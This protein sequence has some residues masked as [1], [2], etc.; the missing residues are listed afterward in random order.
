MNFIPEKIQYDAEH[1]IFWTRVGYSAQ[2]K[3]ATALFGVT[4][5]YLYELF[6]QPVGSELNVRLM[7][8][9]LKIAMRD[10]TKEIPAVQ[11]EE[12]Y[13]KMYASTPDEIQK[14]LQFL[15]TR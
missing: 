6:K 3:Q 10:A 4:K 14:G 12:I 15:N 5:A 1:E 2:R 8:M 7:N 11:G 13:R 9:W